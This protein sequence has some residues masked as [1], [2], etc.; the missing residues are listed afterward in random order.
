MDSETLNQLN[1]IMV[2]LKRIDGVESCLISDNSG[3]VLVN[4]TAIDESLFGTMANV[5]TSSS[6]RLLIST[7]QGEIE[8]VLVESG[9]GKALFISLEKL[10]L[11]L[12]LNAS[13]NVGLIMVRAKRAALK[14]TELTKDIIFEE[15]VEAEYVAPEISVNKSE[16]DNIIESSGLE[17]HEIEEVVEEIA[18][19]EGVLKAFDKVVGSEKLDEIM[20]SSEFESLDVDEAKDKLSEILENEKEHVIEEP[21]SEIEEITPPVDVEEI[22][23]EIEVIKNHIEELKTPKEELELEINIPL[24][25][26]PISFPMLPDVVQ[27]PES[28]EERSSLVLDIYEA[29]FL[30]MSIG[31]S[32]IMGVSPARGII[33]RFLPLK[34]CKILLKDVEV[35][36]NSAIDFDKIRENSEGIPLNQ[37]EE[38]LITDF[39]KIINIITENYGKVMGYDAFRG[40]VR[41]EFKV[42]NSSYGKTMDELGIRDKMHPE[43]M[44]LFN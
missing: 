29:I 17:P 22:K 38:T 5:I 42:I 28:E 18:E 11:I 26:P 31:A 4:S 10:H 41:A 32:K 40:M 37:R 36:S 3:N 8:R 30:A 23:S 35:K 39:S 21:E 34:D 1:N 43:L 9:N 16:I 7:D 27:I 6:K 20:E 24:I 15:S 44:E 2:D 12:L 25:K 19:T 13:A 14:I 33:K